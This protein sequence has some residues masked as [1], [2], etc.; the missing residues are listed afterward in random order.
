V[1][2]A[3]G[4]FVGLR[5]RMTGTLRATVAGKFT[6]SPDAKAILEGFDP[7]NGRTIWSFDAGHAVGLISEQL[8]P[9]QTG[10]AEIVLRAP[11]GGYVDLDLRTGA[12][13]R[14]ARTAPAW[15]RG[16]VFYHLA[17]PGRASA[18]YVGQSSVYPCNGAGS[19][20]SLPAHVPS[21]I[22]AGSTT[23]GM[24]AWSDTTGVLAAPVS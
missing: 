1:T 4:P 24:T 12:R 16:P 22:Q 6:A 11:G 15:C 10:T 8:Q 3:T 9:P 2:S 18:L 21:F 17:V 14:I 19:R 23:D 20:T 5:L 7:A 13:H